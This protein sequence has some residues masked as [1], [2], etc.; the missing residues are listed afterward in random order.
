MGEI[1]DA[2]L[3]YAEMGLAV[4]P[5]NPRNKHPYTRNGSHDASKDPNVIKE[6]WHSHPFANVAI[7]TGSASGIVVIDEDLDES[8]GKDGIHEVNKWEQENGKLPDTWMVIT[9]RGGYH[10]YYKLRPGETQRNREAILEGVDVRGEGGYIIAPPSIHANGN[11]YEWEYGPDDE[12]EMAFTDDQVQKFLDIGACEELAEGYSVPDKIKEGT[13]N[14]EMFKMA[15]SLQGKGFGDETILEAI[16]L[17]NNRLCDPPLKDDELVTIVNG[18]IKRYKKG[19]FKFKEE[20][21]PLPNTWHEPHFKRTSEGVIIQSSRNAVEAIEYDELLYGKIKYNILSYAPFVCGALPWE[22]ERT[23]REW[24]NTDDANLKSYIEDKYGLKQKEMILDALSIVAKKNSYNPVCEVLLQCHSNWDK[25]KHIE[26]LLPDYLGVEKTEYTTEALKL[27]M[28]GAISR[29]FNPGC[30]FDYMLVIYGGQGIGK[31][32]F[33]RRLAMS[34]SWYNDN[35]NTVEGDKA[36]EK[37]RGMWIVELAELLAAKKAREVES[38]KAFLTST[39]DVYRP[40]YGRRTEHRPRVCVFAGTTNSNHFL[41][42]Q[43]GNRRYLPITA[44]KAQVKKSLFMN[45]EECN[46]DFKQAWGEAME[47]FLSANKKPKLILPKHLDKEVT[48][49]QKNFTEE[50]ARIGKVQE[51]LDSFNGNRVCVSMIY[52]YALGN[53]DKLPSRRESNEL[54]EIMN[55]LIT[56]WKKVKNNNGG[57]AK[58]GDY[59]TQVCYDRIAQDSDQDE[60]NPFL[61]G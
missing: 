11:R 51:W 24:E 56:G 41:T 23:F 52:Q 16:K 50:D 14:K 61:Q 8:V 25:Q 42:D 43:T 57:R 3:R 21:V 28:L 55:N 7:A 27:F 6:W 29:A 5:I 36:P 2:A 1:L 15:S 39:D 54:H 38:I 12:C 4:L 49:I 37:L 40:P 53:T 34:N 60:S 48:Q 33:L 10:C 20:L 18:I 45:L 19:V 13:R 58:C 32:T 17:E 44:N 22:S 47:L 59:G 9:G 46:E 35:F 30:K 26:S 31:S